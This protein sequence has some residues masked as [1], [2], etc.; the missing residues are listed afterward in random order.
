MRLR[1]LDLSARNPL[2]AYRHPRGSSLRIVDEVPT[3]VLDALVAGRALRFAPLKG[4]NGDAPAAGRPS[5]R[6]TNGRGNGKSGNGNGNGRSAAASS[7]PAEQKTDALADASTPTEAERR[8]AARTARARR[9]EELRELARSLGIDPSYDLRAAPASDEARHADARLQTLLAADELEA[10]LQKIHASA[11]TAI[12]E[13]GANM[14]HL[15]FGFVEWS[16]APGESTRAAP[17]V[18]LPARLS[19]LALDGAT[20]TDPYAVAA[21]GEDWSTNVTLQEM[22]RRTFGFVLPAVDV[23][24]DLESYFARVET[25]LRETAPHWTLRRQLTL[26]LVSFGKILM[27]RDLDP[28]TWPPERPLLGE[29]LLRQVLGD[30]DDALGDSFP[31]EAMRTTE[32]DID[33]LPAALKPVPP[34]VV[35]ADS[36][37]HSV[38][39]DVQRRESMVVQGPPGTGK[40]QT[41]TNLIAGAIA[42]GKTVLFVAEKKAALD[43]VARRLEDVGL[44]PYCLPLHSHTSDKREFL[45]QL[46]TRIALRPTES[47]AAELATVEG[48]L[49]DARREL[50]G[51]ADRLNRPFGSLGDSAF[52]VFWRA[53]RLG[54]EMPAPMVA[55]LRRATIPTA[56][57]VTQTEASRH[58]A[59]LEAFAAAHAAVAADAGAGASHPWQGMTRA[60]LSFD[61][62]QSLVTLARDARSA[63]AAADAARQTLASTVGGVAWP[64]SPEGLAPLLARV[65]HVVPPDASVP[66][67]LIEGVRRGAVEVATSEAVAASDVRRAAWRAVQGTWGRPGVLLPKD[68]DEFDARFR[69][70]MKMLGEQV[71]VETVREAVGLI[72]DVLDHLTTV[73]ALAVRIAAAVGVTSELSIGLALGLIGVASSLEGL[74]EAA[75]ALRNPGLQGADAP[76]RLAALAERAAELSRT[77]ARLDARFVPEMRPQ[78]SVLREIAGTLATAPRF[79]PAL[80]SGEYRAAVTEY[81]RMCGGRRALRSTMIADVDALLR[82]DGDY[83]EFIA[84]PELRAL[85]GTRKGGLASPFA[86]ASALL[87]WT[88]RATT[89][90]RGTDRASRELLAAVWSAAP[91]QWL[92][93]SAL[94]LTS[95]DGR[96]AATVLGEDLE[97]V[98]YFRPGDIALWEPL[99]FSVV[100]DQLHRWRDVAIAAVR[101]AASANAASDDAL[102]SLAGQLARLRNAWQADAELEHHAETFGALGLATPAREAPHEDELRAVRGALA[103]LAQFPERGLPRTLVDWLASGEQRTRVATLHD[104]AASAIGAID[105]AGAVELAFESAGAIHK[106]AWHGE[107]PKGVPFS[108]RI[109]RLDRAI[110]GSGTLARWAARLRARAMVLD[111]P[112]PAACELLESGAIEGSR[113]RDVYDYLLARTLAELALRDRPELDRFSGSIHETRR[114]QFATLDER[115]VAL[116][117]R[118]VAERAGATPPVRGVGYGPVA[119]LSEQSLIEHEIEKSRRHIPIREVF[120]RAGRAIQALEPCIMMGPQAVAQYLPPGLFHFDLVVMDEASQMRPEDALGAIARGAQLV[121]VGDPK[122]LG[123][124]SFF[125]TVTRDEDDLEQDVAAALASTPSATESATEPAPSASVLERSESILQAAARRYP[126]RML[127]WHYRS[128]YPELIAFGNREF[129]GGGLV[130]FPHPGTERVGDG[131]T[132]HEVEGAVYASS[133]NRREAERLVD[134]VR[135]HAVESPERTLMVVTMNQPQRELVDTLLQ[136]AEK[137][138]VVLA[139]FRERHADS[140]EPLAVKNLENVQ[141]DERDVVFVGTT[142]GPDDRGTLAQH[143]GPINAA[144]GER[145][146][147]VLFTRAKFRLDVFCS[148]DP[149]ALRVSESSPRGLVVLRDYLQFAKERARDAERLASREPESDFEIEVTRALRAAGYEVHPRVGVAGYHVDLAVVDPERPG[150]YVLGIESDGPTYH[151]ARSARDRDRL[152][153]RVLENLGWRIHRLWTVD[154]FRDPAGETARIVRR[155]ERLRATERDVSPSPIADVSDR[156]ITLERRDRPADARPEERT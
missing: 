125:E 96:H 142:Y 3:V 147:N 14:L 65:G 143:L 81:R 95:A 31:T 55:A 32:Y 100:E 47:V 22:C 85:F 148:L 4:A 51:H 67:A 68:A 10:R 141:G 42:A 91:A 30:V 64:D 20:R 115:Y 156:E 6:R 127:R 1:L 112:M 37:Q 108:A 138:D 131:V 99:P 104:L 83:E 21:S 53:R 134:A 152:R 120:R 130:L 62:A 136:Q 88:R 44:G 114:A 72:S 89:T 78:P 80:F 119:E 48:L 73:Q 77:R 26:G 93:A 122:Q 61:D 52:D 35:S 139:A 49:A 129:Y 94:A 124:T 107:W 59:S 140:L 33:A 123:P 8:E 105:A 75:L 63:L 34:I 110:E 132:F 76:E 56:R 117:R 16:D 36:S 154:W 69:D 86:A 70:A 71:T 15:M 60:E 111:G 5:A 27:W 29:P 116:T 126:L 57:L 98:A 19:R 109:A 82:F 43:V 58:R 17:L 50:T 25:V 12:Q 9:E 153:Q 39:V 54:G 38:L 118:L 11:L 103:Y 155:I 145:R 90:F 13:S 7:K 133:L 74:P 2:L 137:D 28:A 144:G 151:A 102:A 121:V 92:D 40:S 18:L 45:D 149:S 84:D 101:A 146:L 113:L 150:C 135:R 41:I 97:A 24:E 128:R 23:D 106:R 46:R 66:A 79:M 87:G